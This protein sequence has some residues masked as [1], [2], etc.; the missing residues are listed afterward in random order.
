MALLTLC[1]I[2]VQFTIY[3][4][5]KRNSAAQAFLAEAPRSFSIP[6][7]HSP[8]DK[9]ELFEF[10][11][12]ANARP[13]NSKAMLGARDLTRVDFSNYKNTQYTGDVGVGEPPQWIPVIYDTGS[14]NL[15]IDSTRCPDSSCRSHEQFDQTKSS[16][17]EEGDQKTATIHF[18][19]GS[20]C[21]VIGIDT[22]TVD[23]LTVP[24]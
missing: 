8:Q 13:R 23:D 10:L 11:D 22:V 17:F 12:T 20:I 4:D 5:A 15:W 2:L 6:L 7:N 1:F 24:G 19:T 18:G 14:S 3:S 21:G 9:Q 16:T